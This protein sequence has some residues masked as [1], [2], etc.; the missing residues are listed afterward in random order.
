MKP[1]PGPAAHARKRGQLAS[2]L[3]RAVQDVLARGISDPRLVGLITVTGVDVAADL[4]AATVHVSV[5][6]EKSEARVLGGLRHSAGFIRRGVSERIDTA[7]VP[8]LIFQID[9]S[10]KRQAG[11]IGALARVAEERAAKGGSATVD[12]G[13]GLDPRG[14]A[15]NNE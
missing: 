13:S 6:P 10:L 1:R 8:D 5:L 2:S 7:R 3:K 9:K 15:G 12:A 4:S 14:N 11:V